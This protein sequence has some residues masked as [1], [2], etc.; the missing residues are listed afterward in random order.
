MLPKVS[1]IVTVF[2]QEN[3]I[4][5]CLDS[6]LEQTLKDIEIICVDDGSTDKSCRILNEYAA[7]DN[8]IICIFHETNKGTCQTRKDG[9]MASCGK[10]VM[11]VEGDDELYSDSCEKAYNAIETYQTDMVHFNTRINNCGKVPQSRIDM[12]SKLVQPFPGR[13]QADNLI[14]SCWKDNK[15]FFQIWGKIYKNNIVHRAFAE[16][17]DGNYSVAEDLYAFFVIAFN[18]SSYYGIGDTLY[19]YNFGLGFYGRDFIELKDYKKLLTKKSVYDAIE[20]FLYFKEKREKYAE[21]LKN[22]YNHFLNECVNKWR[23]DLVKSEKSDGFNLLTETFGLEDV[24]CCLAKSDWN[25]EERLGELM[26]EIK[27]FQHKKRD[28]KKIK[29]I[30]AYYRCISNGGVENVVAMLCNRW[31]D[32]KDEKGEPLYNVVLVTDVEKLPDEYY[33]SEKVHRAYVPAFASS[34]K[35][36]YRARYKAWEQIINEFDIDIVIH[37]L[38]VDPVVYWDTLTIKG[39]PKKPAVIIHSHSFCAVPYEFANNTATAQIYKY[40]LCDG[41][42]T[43][44]E[45]DRLFVSSFNTHVKAIVNPLAF[46]PGEIPL[47][48]YNENTLVWVGRISNEKQPLDL[49]KMMKLVVEKKPDTQLFIVGDGNSNLKRQMTE[50]VQYYNL[51][52]NIHMVGFTLDVAHYYSMASAMICT[53]KYEGF[54]LTIGEAMAFGVPVLSYDMPWLPFVQDGRGIIIVPQ[55]RYEMLAEAAINLLND[56]ER[57]KEV[58]LQGKQ[59]VT[60][61]AEEDIENEWRDYLETIPDEGIRERKHTNAEIIFKYLTLYQYEGKRKTVDLVKKRFAKYSTLRVD[62]INKGGNDCNVI[63]KSVSPAPLFIH[64]PDWL[65]NGITIESDSG[66]MTVEVQCQGDGELEIGLMGRAMR[67]AEGKRYPVWIDCTSFTVNG[68][69]IFDATKT[70]CRDKRYVYKKVAKDGEVIKLE[71]TWSECQSS[72]VLDE[73][74]KLQADLKAKNREVL[75]AESALKNANGKI[76]QLEQAKTAAIKKLDREIIKAEERLKK[77]QEESVKLK[78]ELESVKNGWSFKIGRILTWLPRKLK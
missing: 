10:Y 69:T 15:F 39:Q 47:S 3:Y 2:N 67:N 57:I 76:K 48:T 44:A 70:V 20:R 51:D 21:I 34:I 60:E 52:N 66:V 59:H 54:S 5:N 58:G 22:I 8:R 72:N 16:L 65:P 1:V 42:V 25:P 49:I 19:K 18:S 73:Y 63:E 27:F 28:H 6:L 26:P 35:E 36:N 61:I 32:M 68:E 50:L 37:S 45:C 74:K 11:F 56:R 33:L 77:T 7:K 40:M 31:A 53:S 43:L 13:L 9:V 23:D 17:E 75:S 12:N 78:R 14:S 30:A 64:R 71:V 55:K 41:V 24:L 46:K 4:G 62:I 29:T 38:W